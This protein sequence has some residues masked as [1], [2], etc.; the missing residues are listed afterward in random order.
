L[1]TQRVER[2]LSAI[3][4]ADV[5]GYSRLMELDE[6]GTLRTLTAY[7]VIVD[8]LIA[9]H[10]G[11]IFNTAGD[12]LV[13]DFASAVDAVQCAVE[14]QETTAK[15]NA[16]RPVGEQMRF[17]I[18]IH[19]G[20]IIVQGDNLFGDAVNI[21]ARLEALAEPGGICISGVVRDHI[22]TKL[23]FS[24]TDL[25]E[26]QVKN[27]AQP[28]K[29]YRIRG[30]TSPTVAPAVGS[31][32]PLPD[33]PSIAV[34]PFQNMSG[35]PEQEYFA[36]G[37]VEEIITALS[38]VRWFFV[39]AR[40]STFTYKG[41]A[42]DVK[43]V[44]R[45]LGVRY[46]LEGSVRKG[47]NRVRIT[48]QLIDAA[49]GNHIWA[50]RY[51]RKLA[52]IFAVQDEITER[53]VATI[54]PELYAAEHLRSQRKPPESLDAWE[55]VIRALSCI[56]LS[57]LAGYNEAE[58]LCRR[59]ITVSPNYGQAHSLLSWLLLRRT[60][61][62]GDVTTFFAEAEG[63]ARTALAI[64]ERD[65]WAHLTHGLVLYRQRRHDEA[66]R[67]YRRALELNPN[68]A[69]VHA[70]LG[71]PLAYRG[72][73]QD[74]IESAERAMRLSPNDPLIGRQA[75]H[76]MA[77]AEFAA[78]HYADCVTWARKTIERHPG[79][80]PPYHVLIAA[81]ALLGDAIAAEDAM[82]ALLRLR[83]DFSL[84]WAAKN[85]PL[86]GNIRERL[87]DGLRKAGL[88]ET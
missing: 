47:G 71:L 60:D 30:E 53:V 21:A 52:D 43:E 9:S 61:W 56:A 35:D 83:P 38:K 73:H 85:V 65:P 75:T 15:E 26:Q 88:P 25:G 44:G 57:S 72:A 27:I 45:E 78:A 81:A 33:K 74:A 22:G 4:A 42:V 39:I 12:S 41:R 10:R 11:R 69:L 16:D 37:M 6:V 51:D 24:F 13:V 76:T 58:A 87:L 77:F 28:I 48:A 54:E 67:A 40:N 31:S 20:D 49:T 36:D 50:E 80:L 14:V 59:A 17:R 5:E 34:M 63:E 66:E 7:R 2:K 23:P 32:L 62:S 64:D 79:H 1:E 46:V 86:T 55:C 19:V 3:F 18:G 70:V 82:R 84:T 8:R 29:A 68:F